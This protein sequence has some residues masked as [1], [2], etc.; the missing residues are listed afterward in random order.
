MVY[1]SRVSHVISHACAS[2][3]TYAGTHAPDLGQQRQ[4]DGGQ[5]T[6]QLEAE[7]RRLHDIRRSQN[8]LL[9]LHHARHCEQADGLCPG[10]GACQQAKLLLD[11]MRDSS[12]LASW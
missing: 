12:N 6:Q 7:R 3:F 5:N 10:G 4:L 2:H 11:H 1:V 9:W 8:L